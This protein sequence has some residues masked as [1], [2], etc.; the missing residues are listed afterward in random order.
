MKPIVLLIRFIGILCAI[1][2]LFQ[3][4][5]SLFVSI[6][7]LINIHASV[8]QYLFLLFQLAAPF[9]AAIF[10]VLPWRIIRNPRM[11]FLFFSIFMIS[12]IVYMIS[13]FSAAPIEHLPLLIFVFIIF[14]SQSIAIVFLHKK[15]QHHAPSSP[16][17]TVLL[18]RTLIF[19]RKG[20]HWFRHFKP[21]FL[22]KL[23]KRLIYRFKSW[24]IGIIN[25][26][27]RFFYEHSP[28]IRDWNPIIAPKN[29]E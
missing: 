16:I 5:S 12:G 19:T 8:E 13:L 6:A 18:K 14:T 1:W 7:L 28:L 26:Y 3:I 20:N 15:N 2:L 21:S 17:W 24:M 9:F 25:S 22:K 27:Y 10:T 4:A 23:P 11:W 29:S